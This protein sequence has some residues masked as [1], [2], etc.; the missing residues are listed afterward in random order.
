MRL[1][2]TGSAI[3]TLF[4]RNLTCAQKMGSQLR[5]EPELKGDE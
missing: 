1:F 4:A 3:Q 2:C 5:Q